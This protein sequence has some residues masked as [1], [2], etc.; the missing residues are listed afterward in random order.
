MKI[1]TSDLK[2]DR[3]WRSAIGISEKQFYILLP[4]F[5]N[6]YF[7]SYKNK[8]AHRKV[9]TNVDYCIQN[10]EDLLLFTLLSFKSGL[11]YDLLGIV[12][13]MNG[14]NAQKNQKIGLSI[15]VKTLNNL[16]VMPE[17]K[18]LT[19]KDFE[20]LFTGETDLILDATEQRIQRPSNSKKQKES[21]SG[22]KKPIQ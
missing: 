21:Y 18:L 13:G 1:T 16:N 8:L 4:A 19:V 20:E 2:Q 10:E 6:A 12:C 14:S 22:K 3:Q 7:E 11:T 9:N 5:E 17:R 15:L